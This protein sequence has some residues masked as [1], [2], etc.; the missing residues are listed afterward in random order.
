MPVVEMVLLQMF[1]Q[2]MCD[3]DVYARTPGLIFCENFVN[4]CD[5]LVLFPTMIVN[6]VIVPNT[7]CLLVYG[8]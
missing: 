4:F 7:M 2:M 8:L 5:Y 6:F 3:E 1:I